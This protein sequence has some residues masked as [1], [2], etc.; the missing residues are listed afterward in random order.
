MP[1]STWLG[2]SS[3]ALDEAL[4]EIEATAVNDAE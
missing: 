1:T 3:L 4:I 2:V